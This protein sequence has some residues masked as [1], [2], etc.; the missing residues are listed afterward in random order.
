MYKFTSAMSSPKAAKQL[1]LFREPQKV[2]PKPYLQ[3]KKP[4][5]K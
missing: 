2:S 1:T 5:H 3:L 4:A